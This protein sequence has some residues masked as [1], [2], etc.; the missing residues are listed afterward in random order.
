LNR[1]AIVGG[2]IAAVTAADALRLGGYRGSI[3]LLSEEQTA[4]YSRVPLSKAVLAG[5]ASPESSALP[6]LPEDVETRLGVRAVGLDVRRRR[7]ELSTGEEVSYDGL[8]IATGARDRRIVPDEQEGVMPLRTLD[9]A[10]ALRG[11]LLGSRDVVVV[12]GGFLG[13]EIASTCLEMGIGVT[14]I[15]REPPLARL[16]GRWLSNFV[17]AVAGAQGVRL[18]CAP[19]G[20]TF[21]GRPTVHAVSAEGRVYEADVIVSAV[22]DVPNTEWLATSGLEL[23]AGLVVDARASVTEHVVAAGDVTCTRVPGLG[24][25]RS[26]HWFS[27]IHQARVAASTLLLGL[28]DGPRPDYDP[29]FWTEQFG[30][31]IK[32]CGVIPTGVDPVVLA[33][34]PESRSML[35]QWNVADVPVAAA[36]V[37]RTMPISRLRTL[38][39]TAVARGDG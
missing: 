23:N 5:N 28:D 32:I 19:G 10:M 20:V 14:V 38:A 18:V 33:G 17:G 21:L 6:V 35:L 11:R 9:D 12:G 15:D 16:L 13:M 8:V 29:Y 3:V 27:A 2:S 7:L 34:D 24:Y 31:A 30:L 39:G 25:R 1:I 22:G 26:P 36:T 37:N 4:P